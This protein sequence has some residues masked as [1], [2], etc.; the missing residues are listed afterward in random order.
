MDEWTNSETDKELC[1]KTVECPHIISVRE[2]LSPKQ[3][4]SK[5]LNKKK[6]NCGLMLTR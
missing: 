2:L 5:C 4:N 3:Q 6:R 1:V